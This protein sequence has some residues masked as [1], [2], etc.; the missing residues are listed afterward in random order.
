MTTKIQK[1]IERENTKI[2]KG[3]IATEAMHQKLE[4]RADMIRRVEINHKQTWFKPDGT[5]LTDLELRIPDLYWQSTTWTGCG[6]IAYWSTIQTEEL[7][8]NGDYSG[9][10][11]QKRTDILNKA[12]EEKY[13][14]NWNYHRRQLDKKTFE[15]NLQSALTNL[16]KYID[17]IKDSTNWLDMHHYQRDKPM[18][19]YWGIQLA[20]HLAT[21]YSDQPLTTKTPYQAREITSEELQKHL[22]QMEKLNPSLRYVE[23]ETK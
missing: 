17:H 11:D 23:G 6:P 21:P 13:K 5:S 7:G 16:R 9:P 8:F 12:S 14:F 20:E 3:R 15:K 18:L 19:D 4:A 22:E 1:Q 2:A 10:A